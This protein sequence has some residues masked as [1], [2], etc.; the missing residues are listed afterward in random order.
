MYIVLFD[1]ILADVNSVPH[2]REGFFF[3]ASGEHDLYD[4]SKAVAEAL[5]E[6][7]KGKSPEPTTFTKEDIDAYFHGVSLVFDSSVKSI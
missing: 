1:K 7:G 6:L 3:G 2:G 4:V 5:V